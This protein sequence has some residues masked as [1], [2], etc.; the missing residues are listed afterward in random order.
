MK[1]DERKV[2]T[3]ELFIE[4]DTDLMRSTLTAV[5]LAALFYALPPDGGGVEVRVLDLGGCYRID[6]S[7]DDDAARAYLARRGGLPVLLP[8][9]KKAYSAGEKKELEDDPTSPVRYKYVP[10]GFLNARVVD[11]EGERKK[12][13]ESIEK[14]PKGVRQE[15]DTVH[16]PLPDYPLWAHLC[17]YFGKGSVM[18]TVYPGALHAWHAHQGEQAA[19]LLT[20]SIDAF[21]EFPPLLDD[22][23]GWW[24]AKIA[25]HL[26]YDDYPLNLMLTASS[27]V[28]PSSVQGAARESAAMRLNN[29]PLEAFWLEMYLALVGY[30]VVGMPYRMGDDVLLYY[31][32][33]QD[34]SF[35]RLQNLMREHRQSGSAQTLYRHS[36]QMLRAKLD[37][38][39]AISFYQSMVEHFRRNTDPNWMDAIGGTVGYYYRENGGT[40]IP[41]DET[42]FAQPRWLS[43]APDEATLDR[44][45]ELLK[46]HY[47]LIDALRGQPPKYALTSDEL[48]I[49][50]DYRRFITMGEG[51][52]W[53]DFTISYNFYRFRHMPELYLPDLHVSLFE[54]TLMNIQNDR[55]DYREILQNEGF[56]NIA[57][58]IRHCTVTTRYFKDVKKQNVGFKVQHGLG[59]DLLRNAFDP[60]AFIEALSAF[61]HE[62]ANE[63][64]RVQA[65][66][67]GRETRPYV[68]QED[69]AEV[70]GLISI[71]GSRVVANLLVAAGYSSA[72]RSKSD[73]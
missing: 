58:A 33:P 32:L 67:Q 36:N 56:K 37:T 4:K 10:R 53:I 28:S 41:F 59:A 45:S 7:Y 43:L 46:T 51:N 31:P 1:G 40:Q 19:A 14:K 29:E 6:V 61:L 60:E 16:Q 2:E 39:A 3:M 23:R 21:R 12:I 69:L 64:S 20:L 8:A 50:G 17:S 22:A 55:V 34:I 5:G 52:A 47:D 63:S 26:G 15:G 25:P 49:I 54:E 65:D 18:R 70:I 48:H 30:M 24:Q 68:T 13:A 71:Y 11:Y 44:A 35:G 9:L 66:T 73:N 27:V 62:Y 57:A 38:L 72:Y 42:L